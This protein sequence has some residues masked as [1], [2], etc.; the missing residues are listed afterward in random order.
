MSGTQAGGVGGQAQV[1]SFLARAATCM[2]SLSDR[3]A[4]DGA[5][6]QTRDGGCG[7]ATPSAIQPDAAPRNAA[8]LIELVRPATSWM[9]FLLMRALT[10]PKRTFCFE[11]C[12][13]ALH[14]AG[15][16]ASGCDAG[17][18]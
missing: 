3:M 18:Y 15:C 4:V 2:S 13:N 11:T 16:A 14:G 17:A 6:A 10:C 9:L 5:T 8:T 1:V 12:N 7:T